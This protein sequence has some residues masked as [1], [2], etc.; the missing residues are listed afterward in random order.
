MKKDPLIKE[1]GYYTDGNNLTRDELRTICGFL[2]DNSLFYVIRN[3]W[4]TK[5]LRKEGM[6]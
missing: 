2:A 5:R 6:L 4:K 1:P 3:W